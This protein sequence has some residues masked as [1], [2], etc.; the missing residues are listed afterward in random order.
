ME[1]R[2]GVYHSATFLDLDSFYSNKMYL[3]LLVYEFVSAHR[4]HKRA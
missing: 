2:A 4:G 3:Y 1:L